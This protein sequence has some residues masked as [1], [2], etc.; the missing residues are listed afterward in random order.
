MVQKV[1]RAVNLT[2]NLK[3]LTIKERTRT[4]PGN[5]SRVTEAAKDLAAK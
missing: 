3:V 2:V 5:P 4:G 1:H